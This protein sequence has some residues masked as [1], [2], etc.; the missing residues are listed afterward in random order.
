MI[1]TL[2]P[3][4]VLTL[5]ATPEMWTGTLLPEE[6]ACLSPRAIAKRRRE[7]TAGRVCAR[8]AL[9]RLGIR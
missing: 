7:F 4:P 6:E 9:G 8:A 2:F 5:S 1:E 3:A